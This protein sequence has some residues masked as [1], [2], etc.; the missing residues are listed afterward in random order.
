M[1][2]VQM[3]TVLTAPF[4]EIGPKSFLR[5]PQLELLARSAGDAAARSDMTVVMTV[6]TALIAPLAELGS[7]VLLFAQVMDA[8]PLGSAMGAVTAE[9]LVDAGADGVMLNHDSSPLDFDTLK[10]SVA[11]AR[12][13]G[14]ETIVCAASED[15][16]VRFAALGPT[17]VLFEPPALIGTTGDVP[18]PW[19]AQANTAVHG[20]HPDVLMMHA[21]GV[22]S[23]GIARS[24][25]AAGADGTGSTSGILAADRPTVAARDFIAAARA[26]WDAVHRTR[27]DH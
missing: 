6:P 19:I 3:S 13:L 24:I 23:P 7:G 21:G 4:F 20:R 17:A 5:R 9:S 1:S 2:T 12:A 25:M 26:G 15:E 16:A 11:K 18:R 10:R 27:A 22:S 8:T 14:L